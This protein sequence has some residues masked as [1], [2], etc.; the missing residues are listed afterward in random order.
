MN[1]EQIKTNQI[2]LE[3]SEDK[4][5]VTVYCGAFYEPITFCTCPA[6]VTENL[7]N[8]LNAYINKTGLANVP[9]WA[10]ERCGECIDCN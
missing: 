7:S 6:K 3:I 4:Q 5:T 2:L 10:N 9:N 8:L 1:M